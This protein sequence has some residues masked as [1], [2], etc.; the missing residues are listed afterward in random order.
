MYAI[1]T[2]TTNANELVS[3]QS[4]SHPYHISYRSVLYSNGEF[5]FP[6]MTVFIAILLVH[7]L[8][9]EKFSRHSNAADFQRELNTLQMVRTI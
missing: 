7:S 6:E 5:Y 1:N 4:F 9:K 8:L 2:T 3:L